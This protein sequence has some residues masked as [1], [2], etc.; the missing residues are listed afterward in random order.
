MSNPILNN[1]RFVADENVVIGE[2]MTVQGTISKIFMLFACLVAG[3]AMS[4][5]FLFTTPSMAAVTMLGG[6]IV[7]FILVLVTCF[8]V[9]IAKYTAAPYAFCEGL[10]LGGFSA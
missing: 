4:L 10:L 7:G 6:S 2:P 5:Y 1:N 3:A 9:R 8:N